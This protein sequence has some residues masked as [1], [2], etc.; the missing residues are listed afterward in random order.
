MAQFPAEITLK[1]QASAAYQELN[2]FEKRLEQVSKKAIFGGGKSKQ[3]QALERQAK[4]QENIIRGAEARVQGEKSLLREKVR[5]TV[6]LNKQLKASQEIARIASQR[7]KGLSQYAS[8]IGP[9]PDRLGDKRRAQQQQRLKLAAQA[10]FQTKLE[11]QL[12]TKIKAV[13]TYVT[14]EQQ[15]QIRAQQSLAKQKERALAATERESRAIERQTKQK[16][17]NRLQGLQLGVGFPLLFGGGVGS[18]AGGALGALTDT[19]GGFGG[20]ILFSALGQQIDNFIQKLSGL[21]DSLDSAENILDG[22]ADAGLRVSKELKSTVQ[23]L[24]DQ[25]KFLQAYQVALGELERRF[26]PN[27][28]QQLSNYDA[29]NEALQEQISELSASLQR[30]LLPALTLVTQ[31]V[32]G[33]LS[34]IEQSGGILKF[35]AGIVPGGQGI[36]NAIGIGNEAARRVTESPTNAFGF[37]DNTGPAAAA[38]KEREA[39][40]KRSADLVRQINQNQKEISR[41]REAAARKELKHNQEILKLATQRANIEAK[42]ITDELRLQA[43]QRAFE[44]E[45]VQAAAA[46]ESRGDAAQVQMLEDAFDI[47]KAGKPVLGETQS[48]ENIQNLFKNLQALL[49]AEVDRQAVELQSTLIQ[50]GIPNADSVAGNFKQVRKEAITEELS[51][52]IRNFETV[53][54]QF[55]KRINLLNDETKILNTVNEVEQTRLKR[56]Q[57][58]NKA[59]EEARKAGLDPDSGTGKAFVDA[60]LKNFDAANKKVD[61]FDDRLKTLARDIGSVVAQALETALVDTI[62]AAIQGADDLNEKLQALAS[63]LLTTIGQLVF[64]AGIGMIGDAN[65]GNILG[66][67]FG[68]RA[69]GGPVNQDTP[70][71]V[72]EKGPE[73]FIPGKSGTIAS[74]DAFSDAAAAMTGTSQAFA[75][76][77]EAMAMATATRS[78]NTAAAAEASAMQTAET[79]FANGKSTIS[80]DT[81]RVGEMDVVT[82]EDAIKIGMQSAKK[83]EANVY[84]GLRNMPAVRGRTGVK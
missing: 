56:I 8:P 15:K 62:T 58:Q 65:Q 55:I 76:S 16:R 11:L 10:V 54:D 74:N 77:G 70:Y 5:N 42:R 20:Q 32:A 23:T 31:G 25:G 37:Q 4:L 39:A 72:G 36:V 60:T 80:F 21:A 27:A 9:Q 84:K 47:I 79:Y 30:E 7:A 34:L 52:R 63:N 24:E 45:R 69:G 67:L 44:L 40:E 61:E 38:A 19:G 18:V 33:L 14:K 48:R 57:A 73:L 53:E 3:Q 68:T 46:A 71:I 82:R 66:Q 2:K 12:A 29:A 75:D 83:A 43:A 22:L 6:E 78:A 1:L 50:G 81:Y 51:K 17:A 13:E 26:G 35:L 49:F 41:A 59:R 64:R 28:V